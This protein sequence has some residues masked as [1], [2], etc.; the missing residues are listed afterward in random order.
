MTRD[1]K[2][3]TIH[4]HEGQWLTVGQAARLLGVS[5]QTVRK[6]TD[7]GTLT[8]LRTQG[9]H[10][11]YN[12]ALIEQRVAGGKPAVGETGA[13][14]SEGELAGIVLA[15]VEER[16]PRAVLDTACR[17]LMDTMHCSA[18]AISAYDHDA[19]SLVA[20]AERGCSLPFD[21]RIYA[22]ADFPITA[23]VIR[24]RR[25]VFVDRSDPHADKSEVEFL[26]VYGD[27]TLLMAP[28]VFRDEV[29]GLA[30]LTDDKFGRFYTEAEL[31]EFERVCAEVAL[32][33]Q[34]ARALEGL[35]R[36]RA[37]AEH[38]R[39]E[40]ELLVRSAQAMGSS[41]ELQETLEAVTRSITET[42]DVAWSDFYQWFPDEQIIEVTAYYQIPE[43]PVWEDWKGTRMGAENMR[44][45]SATIHE[46]KPSLAYR[47][48]PDITDA[49]RESMDE[50]DEKATLTVPIVYQGELLGMLDVGESRWN[51][52]Y[53]EDEVRLLTTIASQ[54][55]SAIHN[56]R[57]FEESRQRATELA[58]LL[59]VSKSLS[60]SSGIDEMLNVLCEKLRIALAVY[61]AKAYVYDKETAAITMVASN[62]LEPIDLGDWNG[63]YLVSDVPMIG[64][65]ISEKQPVVTQVDDP[66]LPEASRQDM[67]RWGERSSLSVPMVHGGGVVGLFYLS[68]T[69]ERHTFDAR[70]MR[71]ATAIAAQGAVALENARAYA[72]IARQAI[73]DGLTGLYNHA[74]LEE[75]LE[76]EVA[77]ARRYKTNLSAIMTDID[78]FKKFN[79]KYGHPQGDKLL[80][81]I[82]RVLR[83][84]TREKVDLVSRYGGEEFCIL[85]PNT[86]AQVMPGDEAVADGV[87]TP[88]AAVVAERIRAAV[89]G[90][91]FEGY[92]GRP[93]IRVTLSL[94]IASFPANASTGAELVANA[95]K[96]LYLAKR[97]GKNRVVPYSI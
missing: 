70:D 12:R 74:H 62:D 54:A 53:T 41:L 30:E 5:A 56:A 75:R 7:A 64:R 2:P 37:S 80:R 4:D 11:R 38:S 21:D 32:K 83:E 65:A 49:E 52:R 36:Q 92:P 15:L 50:Y 73:T 44:D 86:P 81:E 95:D 61:S 25:I 6:W 48:D 27:Q 71:L 85:L 35:H 96:A 19:D 43:V 29:V 72:Q 66:D 42:L 17:K 88:S 26:D 13:A 34:I 39:A 93:D 33:V 8:T 82:S 79:D 9:G 87:M 63:S 40:F 46:H 55:A 76:E 84:S 1:R 31:A 67:L 89:E 78:D 51:R 60:S 90:T 68:E 59:E 28:L 20:L 16:D 77:R 3:G 24:E 18:A 57:E 91:R 10:R 58:T 45:W 14:D 22:L 47:D 69:R 94:G 97:E 23:A